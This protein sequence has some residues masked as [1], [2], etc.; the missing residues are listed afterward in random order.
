MRRITR[1]D[2]AKALKAGDV[3][4]ED[5]QAVLDGWTEGKRGP[6]PQLIRQARILGVLTLLTEAGMNKRI[7]KDIIMSVGGLTGASAF[8]RLIEKARENWQTLPPFDSTADGKRSILLICRNHTLHGQ[9]YGVE[10]D[11]RDWK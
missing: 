10:I 3:T 11:L 2:I 8:D 6:K 4:R 1:S 5:L 7:A 9:Q